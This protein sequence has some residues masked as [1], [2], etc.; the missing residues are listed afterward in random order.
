HGFGDTGL[1]TLVTEAGGERTAYVLFDGNNVK[2]GVRETLRDAVLAE[3]FAECE[4]LT[5]DSHVVN[6]MSGRNPVGLEVDVSEILPFVLDGI[7]RA[8]D[9]LSPADVGAATEICE[10]VEVFGPGKMIQLTSIVSGIVSNLIPL[11][12]L[13]LLVAFFAVLVV[14]MLVL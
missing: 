2:E 7:K 10:E 6:S 5:T 14:C 9:D 8:V 11:C 12:I 13:F 1:V 4:I 3:G